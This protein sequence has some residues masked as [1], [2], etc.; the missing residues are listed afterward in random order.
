M[1]LKSTVLTVQCLQQFVLLLPSQWACTPSQVRCSI[2]GRRTT[3]PHTT[4]LPP[5][6]AEQAPLNCTQRAV[7]GR[8][9][10]WS[11]DVQQA[12]FPSRV[13]IQFTV[14]IFQCM[15]HCCL[16]RQ[17]RHLLRMAKFY[18]QRSVCFQGHTAYT[19]HTQ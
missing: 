11:S 19:V 8:A 5:S 2:S 4:T 14:V 13:H 10:A 3:Q 1:R 15:Q 16:I 7:R 9:A 18:L 12:P 17:E 6:G